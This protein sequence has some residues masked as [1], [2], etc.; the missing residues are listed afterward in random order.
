MVRGK[1]RNLFTKP[2]CRALLIS[3]KNL[4]C[5]SLSR[6]R[7]DN[8]IDLAAASASEKARH[9]PPFYLRT[10]RKNRPVHRVR[11]TRQKVVQTLLI[12]RAQHTSFKRSANSRKAFIM[13]DFALFTVFLGTPSDSATASE[14][15][16]LIAVRM[17]I[18]FVRS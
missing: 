8:P 16:P 7:M 2:I 12:R 13:R 15:S 10:G 4:D 6:F 5:G 18:C 9:A 11:L 3:H 14:G 1:K 17:N